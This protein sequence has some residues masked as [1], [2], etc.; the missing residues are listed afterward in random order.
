MDKEMLQ[1]L[2]REIEKKNFKNEL[3]QLILEIIAGI[4]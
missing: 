2:L 3:K 1:A 4:K